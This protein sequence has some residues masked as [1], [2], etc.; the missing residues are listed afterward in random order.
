[1]PRLVSKAHVVP[2]QLIQAA[3]Y[4]EFPPIKSQVLPVIALQMASPSGARRMTSAPFS[5]GPLQRIP[6]SVM[7]AQ[8]RIAP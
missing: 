4:V 3:S 6:S 5:F 1:M 8:V 7:L 2:F